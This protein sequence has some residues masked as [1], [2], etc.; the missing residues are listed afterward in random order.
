MLAIGTYFF[1]YLTEFAGQ[2]G[3][4][5]AQFHV[6]DVAAEVKDLPW[7]RKIPSHEPGRKLA[8]HI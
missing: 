2:A 5:I 1:L 4:T 6:P 7:I 8:P 3:H